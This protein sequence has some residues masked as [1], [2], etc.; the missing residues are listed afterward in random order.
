LAQQL[1]WEQ[2]SVVLPLILLVRGVGAIVNSYYM[3]GLAC[4]LGFLA[5]SPAILGVGRSVKPS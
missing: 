1:L 2:L 4:L 3:V 5:L